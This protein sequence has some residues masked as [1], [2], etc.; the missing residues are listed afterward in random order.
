MSNFALCVNEMRNH[1][2]K[3][4]ETNVKAK[5]RPSANFQLFRN[6]QNQTALSLPGQEV[7]A[8]LETY[9]KELGIGAK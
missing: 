6:D 8:G 9:T 2:K 5:H 1:Y 3:N 4:I 7:V